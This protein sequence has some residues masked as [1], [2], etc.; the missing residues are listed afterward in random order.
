[1][2]WGMRRVGSGGY[3]TVP[4]VGLNHASECSIRVSSEKR[5]GMAHII[6]VTHFGVSFVSQVVVGLAK[7]TLFLH[8]KV[9][10]FW[11]M[12]AKHRLLWMCVWFFHLCSPS[13]EVPNPAEVAGVDSCERLV[14]GPSAIRGG[15]HP[16]PGGGGYLRCLRSGRP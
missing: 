6:A 2:A 5:R 10:G 14:I 1:M 12:R 15:I 9:T 13:F 16:D 3:P 7:R 8:T 11:W 4:P